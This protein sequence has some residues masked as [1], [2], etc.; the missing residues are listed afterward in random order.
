VSRIGNES[1]NLSRFTWQAVTEKQA[2]GW[3]LPIAAWL[4]A[5][6]GLVIASFVTG[7][8]L[9]RHGTRI[10]T[11]ELARVQA[12][13][14]PLTQTARQLGESSAAFDRAVL[15]VLG[16]DSGVGHDALVTAAE[17][18]A[19]SLNT[20]PALAPA[21]VYASDPALAVAIAN[22]Q[23]LGFR[24]TRLHEARAAALAD[25]VTVYEA[26]ERRISAGGSSGVR[27][28]NTVITRPSMQELETALAAARSGAMHAASA[29]S[30]RPARQTPD[31][32]RFL[33]VLQAH[34]PELRESPGAAWLGLIAEDFD[35]AVRLRRS[36]QA[37]LVDIETG[38]A[39]FTVDGELL[40]GRIRENFEIP[41]WARFTQATASATM[42]LQRAQQDVTD[43]TAKAVLAALLVLAVTTIMVTWPIRRLTVGARRLATGDLSARV[44]RGGAS[45]VDALACAFNQMAA[46]LHDAERAVRSYQSQLE[47]RVTERTQQLQHLAEHDPLTNLP[48]R[49][50]LFQYLSDRIAAAESR[51]ERLAVLFLDLDNFKTVNDSLGHEFGDRVLTEI[52][53]RLRMLT[54]DGGFIARLGGDEFTLV[55]PFSGSV[56]EIESRASM[57]VSQFQR[58]LQIDRREIAVGVSCGAAVFPDHGHDAASLL[59][60]ADAALFRAKEL[61]RN[62][63]CIYD[64]ALLVA[65]SNRFRV[66]QALRRAIDAGE[67][68]LHYQPQVSLDRLEVTAV[69]ALLRWKQ[70]DSVILPAGEFIGIAE[71]SGLMLDLNDWILEQAARDVSAWRRTGWSGA[72]VAI[73]VSAQQVMAGDFLG[74]IE[75]L[76]ARHRLPSDAIELELTE[77]MLQTGAIT[78]DTL[79]ALRLLG[80]AT[81][82]DDFGTGY[83]SLTS[84]EQLPLSGVKL[85]R[86]VIAEVDCNPRAASIA[87][88]MVALCHSLGLQ[89]TVEGVER[90]SQLDFLSA[91]RDV[92]VQGFLVSRPVGA[93]TIAATVDGMGMRIRALLE[94]AER[95]RV[96]NLPG[97]PA[98]A[99]HRLRRRPPAQ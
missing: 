81:S 18:L 24:L 40:T 46:E 20:A 7:S 13:V 30:E 33:S 23:A 32:Q 62:R 45:E 65:A 3:G 56:G 60:A 59:R 94:V 52:G 76:L 73:N 70:S 69:E 1:K 78:V 91:S 58:P 86:S 28:G 9:A 96:E 74:D 66:E 64:P 75:R 27:V 14:E 93:E 34:E 97:D 82:L 68:V 43:A 38:R 44:R 21:D 89:V 5:G 83:S 98:G 25:L 10:A 26:L 54:S 47:Q 57:L 35:A 19:D 41:A 11:D 85:D 4:I 6:F 37:L 87:S 79:R 12:Q 42:A 90:A 39:E 22:H 55:Y 67:F 49:R 88:S 80:I 51:G 16:T 8:L 15:A 31:E 48:N 77:N 99:I 72:R 2:R 92:N 17:R 61:G 71:Q 63:L 50:Q 36:A 95:G 84:L 29:G 53:D